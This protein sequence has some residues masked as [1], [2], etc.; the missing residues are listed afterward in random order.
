MKNLLEPA[1]WTFL[2]ILG[3]IIVIIVLSSKNRISRVQKSVPK[4]VIMLFMLLT[5][6]APPVILP[7][8]RGPGIGIPS[9]IS[10]TLGIILIALNFVI[11]FL[12]QRKIGTIPGLKEKGNMVTGGIYG[13][14]RHPLY[15]SNGLLA[16]G[17]AILFD[18]M[19]A[20]VFSICYFFLFLPIIY[21]E[22]KDLIE[23]YGEKY[24]KYKRKVP[25]R[26]IPRV[27]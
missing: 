25:W 9:S 21:F 2:Y 13:I 16:I 27:V 19:Y 18:A 14:I 10:I 4:P 15:M 24:L 1:I 17:L 8:A 5:F 7:F 3:Y 6:I 22:E 26:M 11:K 12:G 23:K 20:L